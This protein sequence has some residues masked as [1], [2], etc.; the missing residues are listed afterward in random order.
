MSLR[1]NVLIFHS[2]ALG[3]F[4]LS[5]AAGVGVRAGVRPEPHLLRRRRRQKGQL[6]ER[7][8]RIESVDAEGGWHGLFA[9]DAAAAAA[10]GRAN[11]WPAPTRS[12]ASSPTPGVAVG[13][14]RAGAGRRTPTS[15]RWPP[16]RRPTSPGTT[17]TSSLDQ[18][19]P[20][21]IWQ[22]G[23]G[24]MLTSVRQRGL[25]MTATPGG[26]VVIH[27]GGSRRPSAGR[28]TGSSSWPAD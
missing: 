3:D 19:R 28:S 22:Q 2:G 27:P 11:C 21:V 15:C 16:T 5:L 12:P 13:A 14:E 25:G 7:A 10:G 20:A 18:L 17:P 4:V 9:A 8:L 24:Q 6:A 26:P 23:V 1:R